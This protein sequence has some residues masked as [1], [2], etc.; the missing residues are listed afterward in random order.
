M[1]FG[2]QS[3]LELS[4]NHLLSKTSINDLLILP[5]PRFPL[6][7]WNENKGVQIQE[8]EKPAYLPINFHFSAPFDFTLG[9]IGKSKK[10]LRELLKNSRYNIIVMISYG[11]VLGLVRTEMIQVQIFLSQRQT[12]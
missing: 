3:C 7:L 6:L 9:T 10:E 4:S 11:Y 12:S 5:A 1:E 2:Q 8:T